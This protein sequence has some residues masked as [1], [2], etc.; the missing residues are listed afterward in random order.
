[1][2]FIEKVK[3]WVNAT[4]LSN[5]GWGAGFV[6]GLFLGMPF[7]AGVCAGIFVHLNWSVVKDLYKGIV[8]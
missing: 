1:M 5:L 2:T 4:G 7:S 6:A 8:K 3:E